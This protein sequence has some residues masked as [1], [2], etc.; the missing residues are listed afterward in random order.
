[1]RTINDLV[2]VSIEK[3]IEML[4]IYIHM[5]IDGLDF[6]SKNSARVIEKEI[7]DAMAWLMFLYDA[8]GE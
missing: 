2:I 3:K 5:L 1:M 4:K 6:F 7:T 8:I